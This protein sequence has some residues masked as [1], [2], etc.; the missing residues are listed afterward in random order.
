MSLYQNYGKRQ[1]MPPSYYYGTINNNINRCNKNYLAN[2]IGRNVGDKRDA[3]RYAYAQ[4]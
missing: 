2:F 1:F 4:Y 3:E